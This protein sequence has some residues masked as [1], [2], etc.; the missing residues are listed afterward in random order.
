[1]AT[2]RYAHLIVKPRALNELAMHKPTEVG[3][4]F[5]YLG[6]ELLADANI[7]INVRQVERVPEGAPSHVDRHVHDVDKCYVLLSDQPGTLE[8]EVTL[9][10]EQ[11]NAVSPATVYVPKGLP[12][13]IWVKKGPGTF[14]NILPAGGT[15]AEHV[16]PAES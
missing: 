2:R 11:Y 13:T 12:H 3:P 6:S 10:D 9:G 4:L 8:V 16:F 5:N 15:Y 7:R 14:L 1:M